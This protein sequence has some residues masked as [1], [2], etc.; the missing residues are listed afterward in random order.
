MQG[1]YARKPFVFF[2]FWLGSLGSAV[3]ANATSM[4]DICTIDRDVQSQACMRVTSD[5]V[6]HKH[7]TWCCIHIYIY[8]YI[9]APGWAASCCQPRDLPAPG[10]NDV[11]CARPCHDHRTVVP[12]P[13]GKSVAVG[14]ATLPPVHDHR[15]ADDTQ[16]GAQAHRQCRWTETHGSLAL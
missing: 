9:A 15:F 11:T 14:S 12:C 2:L 4:S 16:A 3:I 13:G 5:F 6:A 8:T 1:T 10:Y 7:C